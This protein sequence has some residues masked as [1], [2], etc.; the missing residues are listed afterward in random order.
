MPSL[1]SCNQVHKALQPFVIALFLAVIF[2]FTLSPLRGYD[3]W[4][5]LCV[6]REIARTHSIPHHTTYLGTEAYLGKIYYTVPEWLSG[7]IFYQIYLFSGLTGLAITKAIIFTGFAWLLIFASCRSQAP[8]WLTL[9]WVGL[10]M[11]ILK[12]RFL[13]RTNLFTDLGLVLLLLLLTAN[14]YAPM[15]LLCQTTTLF[16]IW[17]NLHQGVIIGP[18]FLLLWLGGL[19]LSYLQQRTKIIRTYLSTV[20]LILL[21]A[22]PTIFIKPGGLK[23]IDYL[24]EGLLNDPL[25]QVAEWLPIPFNALF[26]ALGIYL[27]IALLCLPSLPKD[28]LLYSKLLCMLAFIGLAFH[29]QRSLGE[30][31]AVCTPFTATAFKPLHE[32]LKTRYKKYLTQEPLLTCYVIIAIVSW[33]A[34]L[35][36]QPKRFDLKIEANRYPIDCVQY[37]YR[38]HIP[39]QIFNSYEFGSFLAWKN[40]PP[41]IHGQTTV[42]PEQLLKDYL[43]ILNDSPRRDQLLKKYN[44]RSCLLHYPEPIDAHKNF[45]R[46]LKRSNR[47]HLVWFDDTALLFCKDPIPTP[48]LSH[49]NPITATPI[50]DGNSEKNYLELASQELQSLQATQPD[51]YK[52]NLIKAEIALRQGNYKQALT[53]CTEM[54]HKYG[55]DYGILLKRGTVQYYLHDYQ[56]ALI[57]LNKAL[58]LVPDSIWAHYDLAVV[59]LQLARQEEAANNLNQASNYMREAKNHLR[60]A[61]SLNPDFQAAR[62]LLKQ[63]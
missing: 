33:G 34:Y 38:H 52:V 5:Y 14:P 12:S 8:L 29:H 39:G 3:F 4:F 56:A 62:S 40:I 43:D 24:Q 20:T 15:R 31:V 10:S 45:I 63:L 48:E 59:K 23:F 44:I 26:G 32:R 30:M 54:L 58:R 27:I 25:N 19:V 42:Y 57:D 60:K 35:A 47:W 11:Y 1:S 21:T 28:H 18:I 46:Y 37:L 61:L 6:G 22:I 2:I 41:F 49:L 13:L 50:P 17:T 9:P 16:L 53:I 7:I 51:G 36:L 55:D